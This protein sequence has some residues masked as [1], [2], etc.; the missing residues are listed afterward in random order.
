MKEYRYYV[1]DFHQGIGI[2][3]Y[4]ND[5]D[6]VT[7]PVIKNKTKA[8]IVLTGLNLN[9]GH[10]YSVKVTALNH[11]DMPTSLQSRGVMID[12]S[13]PDLEKVCFLN[14][15]KHCFFSKVYLCV[16]SNH[17]LTKQINVCMI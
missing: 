8:D 3:F 12:S 17:S 13:P 11:A 4:P 6:Y 10:K 2:K 15:I 14:R 9:S 1:E 5:T 7:L 16:K